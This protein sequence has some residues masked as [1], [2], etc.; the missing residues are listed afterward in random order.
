VALTW[1]NTQTFIDAAVG[2][3]SGFTLQYDAVSR[4]AGVGWLRETGAVND[5]IH[6]IYNQ[7]PCTP[8]PFWSGHLNL[9]GSDLIYVL[10][11]RQDGHLAFFDKVVIKHMHAPSTDSI[12]DRQKDNQA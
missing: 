9:H 1:R 12:S 5:F 8:G 7:P 3:L 10:G 11:D 6:V 2:V 4:F